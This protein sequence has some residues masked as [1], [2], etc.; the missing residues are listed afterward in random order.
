MI[1]ME[2]EYLMHKIIAPQCAIHSSLM[3]TGMG[4]EMCVMQRRGVEDVAAYSVNS[5]V[6]YRRNEKL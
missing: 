2:T 4:W 1:L 6:A 5:R 3:Q